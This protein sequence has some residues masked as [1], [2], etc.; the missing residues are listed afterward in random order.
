MEAI[1]LAAGLGSRL[2]GLTQDRPKA[3]VKVLDRPLIDYTLELLSSP[4]IEAIYIVGGYQIEVLQE[5]VAKKKNPK[6]SVVEN[7][8]YKLGSTLTLDKAINQIKGGFL[9]MNADHIYSKPFMD[10]ILAAKAEDKIIAMTDKDRELVDDDMKIELT[11]SKKI[12]KISKKLE[13]FDLGYIGM[14]YVGAKK[15]G[16]YKKALEEVIANTNGSANVEA[17]LDYLAS[18]E[19]ID[20][21]DLSGIGWHEVD[22]QEDLI[23]AEKALK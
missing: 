21:L 8:D 3:M 4:E 20:V 18:R 6:V 15:L 19:A 5:H 22:S 1:V 14:T 17:V 7:K 23:K 16:I 11:D 2:K 10:K 9:L 12:K 13:R